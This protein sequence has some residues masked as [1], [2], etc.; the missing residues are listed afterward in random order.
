[1]QVESD[2]HHDED[3]SPAAT[4]TTRLWLS[5][6]QWM[7]ILTM[8]ERGDAPP[9]ADE[10]FTLSLPG[11]AGDATG[12]RAHPR[13]AARFRCI[14]RLSP[15]TESEATDS[16]TESATDHGTY[17]V[18]SRNI[19][20]GGV[21]FAHHL[22]ISP[23]TRCTIALQPKIGPGIVVAG[24]V[25]WSREDETSNTPVH[26]IGVT[27]DRPIEVGPFLTAA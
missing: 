25:A 10:S 19:S 27:F 4:D 22:P 2:C 8:I 20:P 18:C 9:Q 21:G 15:P 6:R 26:H 16:D 12:H 7:S 5:D 1:M 24:R 13:H 17:V 23:G 14:I 3:L 11:G